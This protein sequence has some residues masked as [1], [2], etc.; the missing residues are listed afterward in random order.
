MNSIIYAITNDAA[1]III[2]ENGIE[3]DKLYF[4]GLNLIIP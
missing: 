3:N 4:N 2:D 1:S